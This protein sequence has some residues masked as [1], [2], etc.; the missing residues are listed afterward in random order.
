M[1]HTA[2]L[3][4]MFTNVSDHHKNTEKPMLVANTKQS[5][6]AERAVRDD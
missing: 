4:C 5:K 6:Q 2:R 1:A 3:V